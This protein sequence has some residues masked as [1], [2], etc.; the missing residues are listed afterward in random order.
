M[1]TK[2]DRTDG[3][4]GREK[5]RVLCPPRALE[6]SLA[7]SSGTLEVSTCELD[8]RAKRAACGIQVMGLSPFRDQVIEDAHCRVPPTV[9]DS[10]VCFRSPHPPLLH[11]GCVTLR[12]LPDRAERFRGR[13]EVP[14]AKLGL[15]QVHLGGQE[16][17]EGIALAGER[18]RPS[19][20]VQTLDLA[21][22]DAGGAEHVER[23]GSKR[24]QADSFSYWEGFL[25][26]ADRLPMLAREH[27]ES[28]PRHECV[29]S[30]LR[31][32]AAFRQL[33]SLIDVGIGLVAVAAKPEAAREL[34][35]DLGRRVAISARK[36]LAESV[37]KY[38]D[39]SPVGAV[40]RT[41]G[42]QEEPYAIRVVVGPELER[43]VVEPG[44][45]DVGR[46][47][48]VAVAGSAERETRSLEELGIF[49]PGRLGVVKSARIVM[50]EHLG[51]V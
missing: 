51:V 35:P 10:F 23:A 8:G 4:R 32:S 24:T 49:S 50:G 9:D 45:R 46:E 40:P 12:V 48:K 42:V 21:D 7:A 36:E 20:V 3:E 39:P 1:G 5:L 14:E 41:A 2:H 31:R 30:G 34:D 16:L 27:L 19:C 6:R 29:R 26:E 22:E 43:G 11:S 37:L 13:S 17:G 33:E 38:V 25:R 18:D 44:G 15:V 28:R 47:G